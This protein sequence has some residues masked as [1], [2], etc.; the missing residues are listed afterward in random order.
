MSTNIEEAIERQRELLYASKTNEQLIMVALHR[1]LVS[2]GHDYNYR[3]LLDELDYRYRQ[4]LLEASGEE[5]RRHH[6]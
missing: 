4:D 5:V 1:V 6:V 3:A 2:M